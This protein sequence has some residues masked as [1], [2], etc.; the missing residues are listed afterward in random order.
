MEIILCKPN[1]LTELENDL[2]A[3]KVLSFY[4]TYTDFTNYLFLNKK[5]SHEENYEN[6]EFMGHTINTIREYFQCKESARAFYN[7]RA[8]KE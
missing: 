1:G 2:C 4:D 5:V 8:T 6:Q 3:T 7:S